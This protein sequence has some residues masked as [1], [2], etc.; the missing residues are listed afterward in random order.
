[1]NFEFLVS[2]REL[3]SCSLVRDG[4]KGAW[5]CRFPSLQLS[6]AHLF[7]QHVEIYQ[8]WIF[9]IL[10][11]CPKSVR[12]KPLKE[13]ANIGAS[14]FTLN[15]E[16]QTRF[17]F[18]RYNSRLLY[19]DWQLRRLITQTKSLFTHFG[20]YL[21]WNGV[22]FQISQDLRAVSNSIGL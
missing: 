1:M 22:I 15:F 10:P 7:A 12:S 13:K 3:I 4:R 14:G 18:S 6:I 21:S 19:Q 11:N 16:K 5:V 2:F 8:S 17:F 9:E 20:L